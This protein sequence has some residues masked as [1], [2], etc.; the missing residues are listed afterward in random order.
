M[1]VGQRHRIH[2]VSE[3]EPIS[4]EI[5]LSDRATVHQG[6]IVRQ[7]PRQVGEMAQM[8]KLL[9]VQARMSEV[10]HTSAILRT[11]LIVSPAC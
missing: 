10:R 5:L 2:H 11:A 1:N 4:A 8:S 7:F 3:L 6:P 9:S